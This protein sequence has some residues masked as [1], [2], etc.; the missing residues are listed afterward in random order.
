[1]SEPITVTTT[2]AAWLQN[3]EY[4]G[5]PQDLIAALEKGDPVAVVNML[6]LY[7]SPAKEKFS[8]YVRVGEADVTVRLLPRDEQTRLAL[9][10]LNAKLEQL[11]GAYLQRQQEIMEQ[12][13]KL[14]ALDYVEAG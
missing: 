10:S 9:A 7:G 4:S 1:M 5:R 3:S 12:I 8:D 14:Q 11:R 6:V 13:S 2:V